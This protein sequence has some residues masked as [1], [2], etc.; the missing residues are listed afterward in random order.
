MTELNRIILSFFGYTNKLKTPFNIVSPPIIDGG[1]I[2]PTQNPVA[3]IIGPKTSQ[4]R[5]NAKTE[6]T[7]VF[8]RFPVT[9]SAVQPAIT[10]NEQDIAALASIDVAT[11]RD[12]SQGSDSVK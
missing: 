8:L 1:H 3:K 10:A 2:L 7:A 9:K 4:K 6:Y 11:K 12:F 5:E